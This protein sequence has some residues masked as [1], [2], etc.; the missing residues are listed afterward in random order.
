MDE[1]SCDESIGWELT[2]GEA[3]S[4]NAPDAARDWLLLAVVDAGEAWSL[5][6]FYNDFHNVFIILI[7]REVFH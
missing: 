7:I 4:L 1:S 2:N 6:N 3:A 5:E